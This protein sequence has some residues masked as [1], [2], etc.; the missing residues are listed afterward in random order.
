M[1]SEREFF[2]FVWQDCYRKRTPCE[3][4]KIKKKTKVIMKKRETEIDKFKPKGS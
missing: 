4:I 1:R 2:V 3:V